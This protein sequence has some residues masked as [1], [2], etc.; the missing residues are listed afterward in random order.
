MR[1]PSRAKAGTKAAETR[2]EGSRKSAKGASKEAA[3]PAS[4]TAGVDAIKEL[5]ATSKLSDGALTEIMLQC[6]T[7]LS[8]RRTTKGKAGEPAKAAVCYLSYP[9]DPT[10]SLW[11]N[12]FKVGTCPLA[13]AQAKGI[14]ACG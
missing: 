9:G 10:V 2:R 11:Q 7:A 4:K 1:K 8:F 12:G 3:A 5:I 14:P 6:A 13:E